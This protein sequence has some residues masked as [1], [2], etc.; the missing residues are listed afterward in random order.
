MKPSVP[1]VTNSNHEGV[2][3]YKEVSIYVDVFPP[4]F[5]SDHSQEMDLNSEVYLGDG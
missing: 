3:M 1:V 2:Y 5:V 4:R